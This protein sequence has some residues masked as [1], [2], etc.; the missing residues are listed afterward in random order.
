[1]NNGSLEELVSALS[2]STDQVKNAPRV[3][4]ERNAFIMQSMLRDVVKRGTG[5]RAL[6]TKT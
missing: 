1:M 2:A 5:R 3:V 4:D 6:S